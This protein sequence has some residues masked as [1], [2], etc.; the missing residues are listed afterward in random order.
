M[1]IK[2]V[3]FDLGGVILDSPMDIFASFERARGLPSNFLN[4]LIADSGTGGA[5]ARLERGELSLEQFFD[6]FDQELQ[7]AGTDISSR[8]LMSAVYET[9]SI[10]PEMLEAVHRIRNAGFKVAALTN[11]WIDEDAPAE[12]EAF[13][14]EFDVFVESSKTGMA[15]PDPRIYEMVLAEL[16]IDPWE[17]VFLDDLGRNLKPARRM[18]M[19]TIKVESVGKALA[20][21]EQALDLKLTDE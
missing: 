6:V 17:A 15:K 12:V 1:T 21:L 20:E 3:I 10:R 14:R 8:E 7:Q 2:A 18:G 4:H 9:V 5:W 11:N 19:I 13:K 16:G